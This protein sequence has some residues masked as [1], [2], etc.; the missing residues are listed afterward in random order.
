LR[1]AIVVPL[2]VALAVPIAATEPAGNPPRGWTIVGPGAHAYSVRTDTAEK[3]TGHGSGLLEC[4][5]RDLDTFGSLMQA[6]RAD[7]LRG[8]RIRFSGYLRTR[9]P[10][11]WVALWMRVD[12]AETSPLAFDNMSDRL[13]RGDTEWSPYSIVLD[14]PAAAVQIAFGA[15][16]AGSGRLWVDD[17]AI[18]V[19]GE[20]VATTDLRQPAQSSKTVV[21]ADV[22]S[23]PVNL[24]FDE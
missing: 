16:L 20:Q 11:Y 1:I 18:E 21:G 2:L 4:S 5:T 22:P 13:V 23:K 24:G 12:G 17:L 3:R 9:D 10:E 19:V 7:D 15:T 8:R 6:I 14:V